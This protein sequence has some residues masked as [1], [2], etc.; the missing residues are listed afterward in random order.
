MHK[1]WFSGISVSFSYASC[2]SMLVLRDACAHINAEVMVKLRAR[3]TKF[4]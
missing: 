3:S 2:W 4:H 1:D